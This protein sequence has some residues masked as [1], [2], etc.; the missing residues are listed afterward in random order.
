MCNGCG[1]PGRG[2]DGDFVYPRILQ[3]LGS[4]IATVQSCAGTGPLYLISR[5]AD[6]FLHPPK[7]LLSCSCS[8]SSVPI[9]E[10][11][12]HTLGRYPY[13]RDW[14]FDCAGAVRTLE[15]EV[16]GCVVVLQVCGHNPTGI[17]P[18]KE[19]WPQP[20]ECCM[21]KKHMVCFDFA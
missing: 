14:V 21:R 7:V 16:E 13:I 5:F 9:F 10:E 18:V 15:V 17:D 3:S 1:N 12:R 6:R 20:L 8:P 11:N 2:E 19:D 4:C